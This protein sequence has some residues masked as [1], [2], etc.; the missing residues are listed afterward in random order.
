MCA[1]N[2][3]HNFNDIQ[4]KN[5]G[6]PEV[7]TFVLILNVAVSAITKASTVVICKRQERSPVQ[8]DSV[9]SVG[10]NFES[11]TPSSIF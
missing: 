2:N 11:L 5:S 7:G 10:A 9:T 8:Q 3:M 6:C 1:F 4:K